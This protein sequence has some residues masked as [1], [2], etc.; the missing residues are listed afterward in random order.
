[1]RGKQFAS[2]CGYAGRRITPAHAGKTSGS[3]PMVSA[4]TDHP[5]ACG[6]NS[7][8]NLSGD[9]ELGSPPRMR[10]KPR[11][12]RDRFRRRRITPAHAGKTASGEYLD[13]VDSDHPRACGENI[14]SM[15]KKGIQDGSPPRMRGKPAA[16]LSLVSARR[17]T[18][19]HAGK[20]RA[21]HQGRPERADHPRACGE[22]L[23]QSFILAR[24]LGSPPR[25]R[26]K[27]A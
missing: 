6:E 4:S 18:P 9:G 22:N 27:P 10:G 5:R 17:I 23:M 24:K 11:F 12:G 26:G 13:I 25:M 2:V 1:M 19:A 3:L 15:L 16:V 20:T 8:Y 14:A 7:A 21:V